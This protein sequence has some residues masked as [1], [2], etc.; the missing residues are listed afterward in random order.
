MP[1]PGFWDAKGIAAVGSC[2]FSGL[3]FMNSFF[4][5]R[6]TKIGYNLSLLT[7]QQKA[8]NEL[9]SKKKEEMDRLNLNFPPNGSIHTL[10]ELTETCVSAFNNNNR[11]DLNMFLI[12]MYDLES[13]YKTYAEFSVT[14][15]RAES[16]LTELYW[17]RPIENYPEI[18]ETYAKLGYSAIELRRYYEDKKDEIGICYYDSQQKFSSYYHKA[19]EYMK[20]QLS[21]KVM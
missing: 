4:Q 5:R 15:D 12:Y 11:N 7:A 19:E 6:Y 14:F 3:A 18:N 1:D 17:K 16:A 2:I 8:F 20:K 21:I 10:V 13:K 9:R